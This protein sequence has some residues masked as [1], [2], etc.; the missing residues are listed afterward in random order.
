ML[1]SAL[2]FFEEGCTDT[3]LTKRGVATRL[4]FQKIS[5]GK[6]NFTMIVMWPST[7][8][9]KVFHAFHEVFSVIPQQK[10]LDIRSCVQVGCQQFWL[11]N[12]AKMLFWLRANFSNVI[13]GRVKLWLSCDWER[14]MGMSLYFWI[15][16]TLF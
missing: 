2:D 11:R 1:P 8:S 15:Q 10:D 12:I 13:K 4:W 3:L 9:K 16:K 6:K 5:C 14:N 7:S